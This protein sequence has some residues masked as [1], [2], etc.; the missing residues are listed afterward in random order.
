MRAWGQCSY[1]LYMVPVDEALLRKADRA[2][3]RRQLDARIRTLEDALRPFA[4]ERHFEGTIKGR[5]RECS[6]PAPCKY[7]TARRALEGEG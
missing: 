5:C 7:E 6:D 2:A 4:D 3:A 1:C